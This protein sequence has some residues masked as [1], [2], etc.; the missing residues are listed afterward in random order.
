[1]F[2]CLILT[3]SSTE[4]NDQTMSELHKYQVLLLVIDIFA[5]PFDASSMCVI[6]LVFPL[7]EYFDKTLDRDLRIYFKIRKSPAASVCANASHS[8]L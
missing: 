2:V 8:H 3:F 6:F 7:P 1:M 5:N 4:N